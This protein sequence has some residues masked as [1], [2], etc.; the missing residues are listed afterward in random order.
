MAAL[1]GNMH[2]VVIH[3]VFYVIPFLSINDQKTGGQ[4]AQLI[5]YCKIDL[6]TITIIY[7]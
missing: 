7:E 4:V 2:C 1:S 6:T 3:F 5:N